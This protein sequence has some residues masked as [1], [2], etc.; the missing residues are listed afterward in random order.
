MHQCV[1]RLDRPLQPAGRTRFDC[2]RYNPAHRCHRLGL[3]RSRI[4]WFGLATKQLPAVC[5][6]GVD[7]KTEKENR[8]ATQHVEK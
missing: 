6:S 4:N 1:A 5:A 2:L 3:G 8:E 7:R